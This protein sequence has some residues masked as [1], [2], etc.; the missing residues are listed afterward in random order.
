M[1]TNGSSL[2]RDSLYAAGFDSLLA[3]PL[4]ARQVADL[5]LNDEKTVA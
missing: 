1:V 5:F 2:S 3:K 4:L